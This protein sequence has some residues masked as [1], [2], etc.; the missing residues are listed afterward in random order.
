[1]ARSTSAHAVFARDVPPL[2]GP[3]ATRLAGK[4]LT[5]ECVTQGEPVRESP[6][7]HLRL[8]RSICELLLGYAVAQPNVPPANTLPGFEVAAT[9]LGFLRGVARLRVAAA[10][11]DCRAVGWFTRALHLLGA[12]PKQA[13]ALRDVLLRLRDLLKQPLSFQPGC[14]FR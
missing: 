5:A 6:T 7:G 8:S 2:L 14:R 11:M 12:T 10:Q 9:A 3:F 4:R 13:L 1:V